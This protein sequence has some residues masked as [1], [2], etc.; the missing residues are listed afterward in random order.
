MSLSFPP[1]TPSHSVCAHGPP[2]VPWK[3]FRG[4]WKNALP[5]Q[6]EWIYAASTFA[7]VRT[8]A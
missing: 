3:R 2:G 7:I 8:R 1:P 6:F 5:L 4:G